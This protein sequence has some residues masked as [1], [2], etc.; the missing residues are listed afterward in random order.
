MAPGPQDAGDLGE[1]RRHV[2][3]GDEV[4]GVV[5]VGQPGGVG[6]PEG[7]PPL[8][9]EPDLL[10]RGRI[11]SSER[12]TPRTLARGN[13]RAR[14]SAASPVPVPRSR[15]RSGT[16]VTFAVATASAAEV[17]GRA[18]AGALV[19][20]VGGAVEEALHRRRITGQSQGAW[21]TTAFSV[22]PITR[23]RVGI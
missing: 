19:P 12:S 17:V 23:T 1:E 16:G 13:S 7:D 2:D 8:G 20:A 22:R 5:V 10:L 21:A 4:E 3:L 15:T 18:G 14:N 6:D 9:V 11:I